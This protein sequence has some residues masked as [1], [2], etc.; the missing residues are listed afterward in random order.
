MALLQCYVSHQYMKSLRYVSDL[1]PLTAEAKRG[2]PCPVLTSL[3]A[4]TNT[5]CHGA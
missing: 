4:D 5:T 3:R 1:K 2:V